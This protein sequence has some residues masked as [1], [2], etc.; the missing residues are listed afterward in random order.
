MQRCRTTSGEGPGEKAGREWGNHQLVPAVPRGLVRA[1]PFCRGGRTVCAQ[2]FGASPQRRTSPGSLPAC[3]SLSRSQNLRVRP[4]LGLLVCYFGLGFGLCLGYI[5]H[6]V[7]RL[8]DVPS[9]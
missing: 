2:C 6:E 5:D 1:L 8:G 7:E 9:R 4:G 3:G